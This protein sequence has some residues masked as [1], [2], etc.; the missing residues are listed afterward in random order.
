MRK[1]L[2][3]L[4]GG[5]FEKRG[6]LTMNADKHDAP[7]PGSGGEFSDVVRAAIDEIC[8]Q[9]PEDAVVERVIARACTIP[10]SVVRAGLTKPGS[11]IARW[12]GKLTP[13]QRIALGGVV[14]AAALALFLVWTISVTRPVS[15]MEQMAEKI[16]QAKSCKY[17]V[18]GTVTYDSP[19]PGKPLGRK[20]RDT[21][22]WLAPARTEAISNKQGTRSGTRIP[23]I[24]S[25]PV[26]RVSGSII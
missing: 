24:S 17:T 21:H 8:R 18:V 23:P 6:D 2:T 15:A 19:E 16:R 13:G 3:R 1:Q 25:P 5:V 11:R 26:N 14:A 4:R 10:S 20:F 9:Q 7:A 12:A 22:Y